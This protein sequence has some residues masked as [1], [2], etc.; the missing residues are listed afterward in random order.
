MPQGFTKVPNPPGVGLVV[1]PV[2]FNPSQPAPDTAHWSYVFNLVARFG[3]IGYLAP[4]EGGETESGY[5]HPSNRIRRPSPT[6][7]GGSTL[8]ACP[9]VFT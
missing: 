9:S 6:C 2:Y 5:N 7:S 3:S 1:D 4:A 8:C